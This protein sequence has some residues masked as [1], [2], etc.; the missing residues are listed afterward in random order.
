M[1]PKTLIPIKNLVSEIISKIFLI[2][3]PPP[4]ADK[5]PDYTAQ[6]VLRT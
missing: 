4:F 6:L 5:T 1:T 2:I 3:I